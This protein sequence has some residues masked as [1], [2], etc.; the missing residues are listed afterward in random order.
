[1][2]SFKSYLS[3]FFFFLLVFWGGGGGGGGLYKSALGLV[4]FQ[5]EDEGVNFQSEDEGVS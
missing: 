2:T 4:L 3:P 1:M 5:R